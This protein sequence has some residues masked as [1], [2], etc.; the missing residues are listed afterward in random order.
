MKEARFKEELKGMNV[1]EL[2]DKLIS[3]RRER[4]N[5]AINSATAHVKDYSQIKKL[6]RNIACVLTYLQQAQEKISG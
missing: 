3:L 5:L 6:R 4:F 1:K 2:N